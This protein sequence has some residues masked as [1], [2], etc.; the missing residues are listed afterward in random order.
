MTWPHHNIDNNW[1]W[2]RWRGRRHCTVGFSWYYSCWTA[3]SKRWDS[4]CMFTWVYVCVYACMFVCVC[5]YIL[6]SVFVRIDGLIHVCVCVPNRGVWF[7][8]GTARAIL[9]VHL[10]HSI[11]FLEFIFR[12]TSIRINIF[13]M[14]L[15]QI[16]DV[17][18]CYLLLYYFSCYEACDM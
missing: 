13:F 3:R 10:F 6:L 5:V 12:F 7:A 11:L 18:L 2:W 1:R 4:R 15:H 17:I 16:L 8:V 9:S 14:L